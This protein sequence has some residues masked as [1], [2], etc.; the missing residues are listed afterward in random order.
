ML[1]L[2][3]A[4]EEAERNQ[5]KAENLKRLEKERKEREENEKREL[6]FRTLE[7]RLNQQEEQV[8]DP[9]GDRWIRCRICGKAST[10]KDFWKYGGTGTVNIGTCYECGKNTPNEAI[11]YE[12]KKNKQKYNPNICPECGGKLVRRSGRSG[13]Y[14]GCKNYPK[15]W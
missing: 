1:V 7:Q 10:I 9:W 12:P 15:C 5:A 4:K 2:K 14:M 8:R 13:P 3:K 11:V 6:F